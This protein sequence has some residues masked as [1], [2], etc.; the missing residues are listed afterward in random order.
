MAT[1]NKAMHDLNEHI[2]FL[3]TIAN[4]KKSIKKT[5]YFRKYF[6]CG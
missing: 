3:K 6:K 1:L 5:P 4:T 2:L